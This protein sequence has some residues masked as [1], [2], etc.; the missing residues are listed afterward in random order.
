MVNRSR[1]FVAVL[2]FSAVLPL[3]AAAQDKGYWR[4]SNQTAES[5]TG[6]IFIAD[7]K[8]TINFV[9]FP[10]AQIRQLTS[11]EISALFDADSTSAAGANLYRLN[12]PASRRFL[13]KNTLCGT[14][15]T[16][17]M[18]TY[19]ENR[20]LHVALFSGPNMP[21]LTFEAISKSTDVCGTFNYTR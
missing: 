10:L 12:I 16:Q 2:V 20:N 8:L 17:W 19:V 7:G 3:C 4:A 11:P 18:V 5:I 14:E 13:H 21:V 15:D 9:A 6:D 1:L